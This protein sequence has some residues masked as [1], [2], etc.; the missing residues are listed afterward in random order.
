VTNNYGNVAYDSTDLHVLIGWKEED[1][2]TIPSELS[3]AY[4]TNEIVFNDQ[5]FI[6]SAGEMGSKTAM[7][8]WT[9][10]NN[11]TWNE[12]SNSAPLP[13]E[14]YFLV[15]FNN[16]IW[17]LSDSTLWHSNNAINWNSAGA[18]P[19][20]PQNIAFF[21][22]FN[23]MLYIGDISSANGNIWASST[24][25]SWNILKSVSGSPVAFPSTNSLSSSDLNSMSFSTALI[26]DTLFLSVTGGS[27]GTSI[28]WKITDWGTPVL[29]TQYTIDTNTSVYQGQLIEYLGTLCLFETFHAPGP[30]SNFL[31][32]LLFFDKTGWHLASKREGRMALSP[33]SNHIL[34]QDKLYAI[35][36]DEGDG[37][38]FTK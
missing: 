37:I 38:W 33:P 26:E 19:V 23:N 17:M 13:N 15:S 29:L 21:T 27:P 20:S 30:F 31:D 7:T 34:F 8:I 24:G 1:Q 18:I 32:Y 6:F 28:I 4:G 12:L 11:L 2:A 14:N 5:L 36:L 9:F 3:I 25:Q 22:A 16:E 10:T 35:T